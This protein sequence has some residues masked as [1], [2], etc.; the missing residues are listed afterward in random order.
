MRDSHALGRPTNDTWSSTG[1]AVVQS[2]GNEYIN[3]VDFNTDSNI[4]YG[5][6]VARVPV[7][8]SLH[9]SDWTYWNGIELGV[10]RVQRR[11]HE[12]PVGQRCH[13]PEEQQRIHGG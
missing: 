3:G 2:A 13:A 11:H 4:W 6:K 7:G 8:D 10:R 9:F 12:H 5:L 1:Q